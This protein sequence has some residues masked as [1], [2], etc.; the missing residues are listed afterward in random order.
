MFTAVEFAS[1]SV[2]ASEPLEKSYKARTAPWLDATAH[3]L[4]PRIP[5]NVFV[6]TT[7]SF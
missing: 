4:A 1:E 7:G 2:D 5:K 6:I 3:K